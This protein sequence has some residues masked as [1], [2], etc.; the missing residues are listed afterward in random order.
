MSLLQLP[1][2]EWAILLP[3]LGALC[4]SRLRDAL[5]AFRWGLFFIG[6]TLLSAAMACLAYYNLPPNTPVLWQLEPMLFGTTYLSLDGL[7]APLLP[8]AA[9]LHFLTALATAR[10]KMRRFSLTWSLASESIRLAVFATPREHPWV[11]VGLLAVGTLPPLAELFNRNKPV[12]VYALHM[13]LF[14]VL[15]VM[16]QSF[17][18][19]E[20]DHATQSA[21]ATVPLLL[22][23][24]VRCGAVPLHCWLTDWFEHASFGNAMLF[25]TP[26]T[27]VYATVR[28][29]LPIAPDWVLQSLGLVSLIT[30]VYA[31]GMA[32][33][34]REARR[35]FSYL[36]ISHSSLVLVGLELVGLHHHATIALT[37]S[38]CLWVSVALSLSGFGLTLRALEA[39]Y[40]RL[41]LVEYHGLYDHSPALAICFLITGLASVGFPGTLGYVAA[42]LLVDGAIDANP[43]VGVAVALAAALNGIAVVRAYFLLFTGTRHVSTI[44][45]NIGGRERFAVLTLAVLILGGGLYPQPGVE[46]RQRAAREVLKRR[47]E[48]NQPAPPTDPGMM[49]ANPDD[50]V[51]TEPES[52]P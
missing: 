51:T 6:G 9:L 26:L 29:V 38:L 1:W 7:S 25:V 23:I 18:E 16:G 14:V 41:S 34:Q 32:V 19:M 30:A 42:E 15:M 24:L 52:Q 13:A 17:V 35:F 27:G 11:I 28:L 39:R 44:S 2:L 5:T 45:L 21:W 20:A 50:P 4:V 33:V 10:T 37:G 40:G 36:F 46:S 48:T 3:L 22:A 49:E 47:P 12:T 31:S 8:L 43:L